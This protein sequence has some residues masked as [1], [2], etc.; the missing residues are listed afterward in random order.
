MTI[1]FRSRSTGNLRSHRG[2]EVLSQRCQTP[3]GHETLDWI[4]ENADNAL[5]LLEGE[6]ARP[7]ES[8]VPCRLDEDELLREL[9]AHSTRRV[10]RVVHV[11][12]VVR[13]VLHDL[14]D[15]LTS[16]GA[17]L[18]S[19]GRRSREPDHNRRRLPAGAS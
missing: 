10:L 15:E 4:V 17:R 5:K 13:R 19:A 8:R 16:D 1:R 2:V 14:A 7:T 3:A 9:T 18:S 12:V 11:D 6:R